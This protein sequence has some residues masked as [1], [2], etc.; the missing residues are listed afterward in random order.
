MYQHKFGVPRDYKRALAYYRSAAKQGHALGEY[1]QGVMY[2]GA[3]G[4][5]RDYKQAL[6]WYRKA[7]DQNLSQAEKQ[8]GYF[9]QCGYSVKRDFAQAHA[10]YL[11]A[12]G[13]G[14]SDAESQLGYFAEQGWDQPQNYAEALAWFYKAAEHGNDNAKENIGYMFQ[15][16]LGMQTDY[17]K[18]M[19]WFVEAA[20]HG[21]SDAENQLGWMYQFGQGVEPDD[22]KAVTWYRMS[23]DQGKRR[24]I[25]NLDQFKGVLEDRG[26]GF[27]E[28]ANFTVTD[29]AIARAQRWV[30][31]QDL[32]S[33]IAGLEGD[34]Q[35]Q[36]DIADQLEHTGKG[37]NDAITKIFNAVGS[38]P[39][40]KFH[41]EAAKYRT[42]AARL[43]EELARIENA[44]TGT[45]Q[46]S[47]QR[48]K[49]RLHPAM[50]CR[51]VLKPGLRVVILEEPRME[52][53]SIGSSKRIEIW[54]PRR[55]AHG[56]PDEAHPSHGDGVVVFGRGAVML[57]ESLN[58]LH[59]APQSL[60]LRKLT[61]INPR[62]AD[63]LAMM[64]HLVENLERFECLSEVLIAPR[65]GNGC[66]GFS[67]G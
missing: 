9:Y 23:A 29:A 4:V 49:V 51:I 22:A 31:I 12:A 5:K 35:N 43:R 67:R 45:T 11:R 25:D 16:G 55:M 17:A 18:A 38:V 60:F 32:R 14:N 44:T 13:H 59:H 24:G 20:A 57:R 7:A 30:N 48:A 61:R 54:R 6:E 33:R 2:E 58:S 64:E 53:M 8:V 37:K 52:E 10:W 39:A 46:P 34:A 62:Q 1:N 15:H 42:E 26:S 19:S 56:M 27:W 3:V 36:D 65:I 28:A 40:V 50:S 47:W 21:D 63:V 66:S 41:I